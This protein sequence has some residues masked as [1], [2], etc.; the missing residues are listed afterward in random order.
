[1]L[2]GGDSR[3]REV[4]DLLL[5]LA[6]RGGGV[7]PGTERV[8]EAARSGGVYAVVVAAD[9]SANTMDKLVPLL[10]ARGIVHIVAFSRVELGAAV[11]GWT[12]DGEGVTVQTAR[13]TVRARWLFLA[14][15]AWAGLLHPFFEGRVQPMR[16]QIY[17][18]EPAPRFLDT[19]TNPTEAAV[20][21]ALALYRAEECDG[22][23]AV[24]GGSP[25]DLAKG[26]A[27]LA[28]HPGPLESY[29]AIYGGVGKI[30]ASV[31]P[32]I[33]MATTAGTGAE[34]GRA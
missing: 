24:G 20:A 33:A 25:I 1:M 16:G 5:G 27:L 2:C 26:V 19:P 9:A 23:I 3:L 32:L 29:A 17:V 6:A 31:A 10:R 21:A 7:V 11:S 14:V 30:G 15:N 13:G 12:T 18:T 28:T 22:I 4:L 34:V 8:R